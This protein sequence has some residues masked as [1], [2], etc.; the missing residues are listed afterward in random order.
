MD[1]PIVKKPH[2][3]KKIEHACNTLHTAGADKAK[4]TGSLQ[5]KEKSTDRSNVLENE[6]GAPSYSLN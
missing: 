5:E 1:V 6:G 4:E 3:C 2:L